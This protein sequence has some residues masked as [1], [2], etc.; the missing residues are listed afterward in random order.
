ML[1]LID[2]LHGRF[3]TIVIDAPPV[4]G[5]PDAVTLVDLCDATLLVIRAGRTPRDQVES[6][7]E[8]LDADKIVG[9]VLNRCEKASAPYGGSSYGGR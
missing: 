7:L 4:L 5:L 2:E 3:D 9:T 8:A 1:D 6:C